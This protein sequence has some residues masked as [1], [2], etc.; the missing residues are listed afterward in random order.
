LC[1]IWFIK[2][3]F[4]CGQK[5]ETQRKLYEALSFALR[6]WFCMECFHEIKHVQS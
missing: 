5:L 4:Q 2:Q 3:I 1:R 6:T